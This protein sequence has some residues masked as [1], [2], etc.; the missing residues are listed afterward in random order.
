MQV[1]IPLPTGI[2]AYVN[3]KSNIPKIINCWLYDSKSSFWGGM[4]FVFQMEKCTFS[5]S[6]QLYFSSGFSIFGGLQ[7]WCIMHAKNPWS[8]TRKKNIAGR[9]KTFSTDIRKKSPFRGFRGDFYFSFF[10]RCWEWYPRDRFKLTLAFW[11]F[12]WYILNTL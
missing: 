3:Q 5:F 4:L 7:A 10:C 8:G 11:C 1:F 2:I 9:R 6:F 12:L